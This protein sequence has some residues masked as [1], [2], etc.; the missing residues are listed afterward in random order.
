MQAVD[1][2][3]HD[4]RNVTVS[5]FL[6]IDVGAFGSGSFEKTIEL[7]EVRE[8]SYIEVL[9]HTRLFVKELYRNTWT[10]RDWEESFLTIPGLLINTGYI[11]SLQRTIASK[12]DCLIL[13]GGGHFQYMALQSYLSLHPT[14]SEQCV[15]YVC[16]APAFQRLFRT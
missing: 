9:N 3:Q 15:K 4:L 6:S 1:E 2:I 7:T 13:M 5:P 11:S 16:V 10:F 8:S 14:P 12:G